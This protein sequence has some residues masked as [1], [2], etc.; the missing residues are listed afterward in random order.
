M[1]A[2]R[3]S[4]TSPKRFH[5]AQFVTTSLLTTLL[6]S[7]AGGLIGCSDE[8]G[9]IHVNR[10]KAVGTYQAP[11]ESGQLE[12]LELKSDGT[13]VQDFISATRPFRHAGGWRID[14]HFFDG[15]D[16]VLINATVGEDEQSRPLA[17]GDIT[18]NVHDH[19]GKVALAR[20]ETADWYYERVK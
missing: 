5:F 1:P 13:Y 11:F 16:V 15:S 9:R 8:P 10:A 20:N 4:T 18:L 19:S 2:N 14:N 7:G 3:Q 12:R 6:V 17:F